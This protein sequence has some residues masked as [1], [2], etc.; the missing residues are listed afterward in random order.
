MASRRVLPNNV[1]ALN[2]YGLKANAYL[3]A[4]FIFGITVDQ[5]INN[6]RSSLGNMMQDFQTFSENYEKQVKQSRKTFAAAHV[7]AAERA[8][9]AI[10]LRYDETHEGRESYRTNPAEARLKRFA[11]G[12]LR[13][14]LSSPSF[15]QVSYNSVGLGNLDLLNSQAPQWARLNFGAGAAAN[16]GSKFSSGKGSGGYSSNFSRFFN[17]GATRLVSQPGPRPG[18]TI[19]RG[20]WFDENK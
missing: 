4:E 9:A 19:P 1:G 3:D 15:F 20:F 17:A 8:Q 18:F 14:A 13:R 6:A 5:I 12:K 7:R 11:G 10:L 16:S 2:D